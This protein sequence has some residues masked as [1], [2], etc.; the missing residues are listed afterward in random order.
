MFHIQHFDKLVQVL[1][2][3]IFFIQFYLYNTGGYEGSIFFLCICSLVASVHTEQPC[4]KHLLKSKNKAACK[5][6]L[7]SFKKFI[8][9]IN[10]VV[11]LPIT[12]HQLAQ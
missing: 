5:F 3:H 10:H 4:L 12:E 8:A 9:K 7:L 1:Q 6:L 11:H 2:L